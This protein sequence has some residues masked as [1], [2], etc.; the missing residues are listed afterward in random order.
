MLPFPVNLGESYS[1][2][3]QLSMDFGRQINP[4]RQEAGMAG[5]ATSASTAHRSFS[6]GHLY[7][8]TII[9]GY[10][11]THTQKHLKQALSRLQKASR[12]K[13]CTST[14]PRIES[15][16]GYQPEAISGDERDATGFFA[17]QPP[18]A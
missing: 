18:P 8:Q 11:H 3:F 13:A 15:R 14:H 4:F 1:V 9:S 2:R 5:A 16:H 17:E 10:F 6:F 12:R 7:I